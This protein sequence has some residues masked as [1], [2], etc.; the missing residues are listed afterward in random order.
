MTLWTSE[1]T[2]AENQL[3]I[4]H[5]ADISSFTTRLFMFSSRHYLIPSFIIQLS[6]VHWLYSL[7]HPSFF[8]PFIHILIWNI[9]ICSSVMHS[10]AFLCIYVFLTYF[11]V[12]FLRRQPT[13]CSVPDFIAP[14][15]P[16]TH[17]I[18]TKGVQR[19]R[20]R[21]RRRRH[22]QYRRRYWRM[23]R[24]CVLP[25]A[26]IWSLA[27]LLTYVW[28]RKGRLWRFGGRAFVRVVI[29]S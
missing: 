13:A 16:Q 2:K 3:V 15:C 9:I 6:F 18:T 8:H 19:R 21:R 20:Q 23:R 11:V 27:P 7:F 25:W 5:L 14:P 22:Q 24:D 29:I 4:Y 12:W 1:I 26:Q 10:I 28:L 17:T